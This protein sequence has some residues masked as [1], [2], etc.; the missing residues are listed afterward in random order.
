MG[1]VQEI[2]APRVEH[3][4]KT[5]R[6]AK[7]LRIGGDLEQRG[8]AR[9]E[10]QIVDDLLVLQREPRE[11][12]RQRE[13]DMM[14]ADGQELLLP[15]GQPLVARVGQALRTVPI[16]TRVVRDGA[17]GTVG[18]AIEMATQRG[19]TA[20]CDGTEHAMVL[21]GQPSPVRLDEAI[22]VFSNDIGHLK[23]WPGHRFCSRRDR[24]AVSGAGDRHRIQRIRDRLQ[25][26]TRE[27]QID[28]RVFEFHVAEQQLDGAQVGARFEQMCGVRMPQHVRGD[29]L[30]E[31]CARV[32]AD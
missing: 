22:T 7:M 12:V 17:M 30:L 28:H 8:R 13:D 3:T 21:R 9:A 15:F 24:R 20:A 5:N 23:G 10:E 4:Q 16:A 32:A 29:T 1:M 14:V 2:L 6:R 27:V 31:C 26:P 18:A 19:R 25:V 11:L